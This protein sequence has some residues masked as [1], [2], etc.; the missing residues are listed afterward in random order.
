MQNERVKKKRGWYNNILWMLKKYTFFL[1][2]VIST[3]LFYPSAAWCMLC[4]SHSIS[5][6]M[7]KLCL[8]HCSVSPNSERLN[9]EEGWFIQLTQHTVSSGWS[10]VMGVKTGFCRRWMSPNF[11]ACWGLVYFLFITV[12][13]YG[14]L[15]LCL[16]QLVF[17]VTQHLG[18]C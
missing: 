16:Y 15:W 10:A 1:L 18:Y 6:F 5:W 3:F 13:V 14:C 8:I 11:T 7:M 17:M 4:R 12:Y 2:Y 9:S